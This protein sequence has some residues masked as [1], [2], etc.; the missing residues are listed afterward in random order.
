MTESGLI[1]ARHLKKS[2]FTGKIEVPALRDVNFELR[3]GEFAAL[4]GPSGSG[5]STLLNLIGALD[6]PT[7]GELRVLGQEIGKLSRAER[8]ELRLRH[9]GF[10]SRRTTW[11]RF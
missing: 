10:V 2:F 1:S 7:S 9:L 3:E 5:K 8:S 6:S 11:S 4:V